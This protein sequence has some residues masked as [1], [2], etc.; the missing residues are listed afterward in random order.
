M[1]MSLKDPKTA[2][3][4]ESPAADAPSFDRSVLDDVVVRL[5]ARILQR[6]EADI[7]A[8][9]SRYAGAI[10]RGTIVSIPQTPGDA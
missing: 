4:N 3:K 5:L 7:R 1:T 10:G 8:D 6:S 2:A 9:R